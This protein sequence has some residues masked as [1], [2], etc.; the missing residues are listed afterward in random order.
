LNHLSQYI[1]GFR[2]LKEGVHDFEYSVTDSFFKQYEDSEIQQGNLEVKVKLDK[3]P[4]MLVLDFNIQGKVSV[5][6]DRCLE[7]FYLPV[8]Y[9]GV[10]YVKFGESTY[11]QSDDVIVLSIEESEIDLSQYIYEFINL[12]L[13]FRR[14]HP[15][16]K[17]GKSLCNPE[18]I[19]KLKQFTIDQ[20][21]NDKTDPRWDGLKNIFFNN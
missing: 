5:M 2:G 3:K 16:T 11:E 20:E 7:Y 12:S 8:E 14:V 18:M 15:V 1:I 10:L 6:C 4:Q 9:D 19:E 21:A 13:P 17:K